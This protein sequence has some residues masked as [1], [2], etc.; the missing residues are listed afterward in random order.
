MRFFK[1]L[2]LFFLLPF[3]VNAQDEYFV[4]KSV[5]NGKSFILESG[6]KVRLA[7]LQVPNTQ[8][9]NTPEHHGRNGEPLGDEARN[10]LS[11]LILGK[12][13]RIEYN[14]AKRDRHNRLLGQVY[15]EKGNWIQGEMLKKGYAM[16]YSFS[17]DVPETIDKMIELEKNAIKSGVGI[18]SNPYFR[19]IKTEE[20]AEFINRYKLVEGTI[21]SVNQS[22]D[23]IYLNFSKEWRGKF[24]VFISHKNMDNFRGIDFKSLIGKKVIVRGW[25]NYHNAPMINVNNF[26]Q[27]E[28]LN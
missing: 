27:I 9:E 22:H 2:I 5:I 15:D 1:I 24:A 17:D 23:N 3:A 10:A 16:V 26:K 28:I 6:D 14:P 12:K 8:E 25:I 7:S 20:A 11:S 21:V 13:I 19:I 4:V 18:W